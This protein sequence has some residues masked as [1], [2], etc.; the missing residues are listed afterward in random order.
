MTAG[1]ID[2]EAGTR[3]IK[4]LGGLAALMPI[5]ATI[6]MLAAFSMAG[7]PLLNGFLSKEM[8]LHEASLTVWAGNPWIL[9]AL[10]TLGA[11]FS[12]AYSFRYVFHVFFGP[13]RSDYPSHPHDPPAG[14]YLPPALLVV[15]VVAIGLVPV[16]AQPLVTVVSAAVVGGPLPEFHL[17]IW[18]GFTPALGMSAIA[19][20]GGAFLLWRH[21]FANRLRMALPRPEAKTMFDATVRG[22]AAFSNLVIDSLHNG[23]LRRYLAIFVSTVLAVGG[24]A[25][26]SGDFAVGTRLGTPAPLVPVLGWMLL[27]GACVAIVCFH[28]NRLLT[29]VIVRGHRPDCLGRLHLPLGAGFGAHP[30]LGRG[31]DGDALAVGA[32]LPAE[33]DAARE[34]IGQTA[35]RRRVGRAQRP[36]CRWPDLSCDDQGLFH[37]LRLPS[38]GIQARRRRHQWS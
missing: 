7:L 26:A 21:G 15:L 34:L 1:M 6:A 4:R 23:S 10:A 29:L 8:M 36:G 30:N 19:V 2:H 14:M 35:A 5:T 27:V 3:D 12:V 9:P 33:R 37:H 17:A 25:F 11:V 16:L 28:R 38:G 31:G 22:F 18:H 20:A 32:Q 13:E 24:A